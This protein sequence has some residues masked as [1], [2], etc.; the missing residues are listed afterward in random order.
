MVHAHQSLWLIFLLTVTALAGCAENSEVWRTERVLTGIPVHGLH[1]LT[2]GPDGGL[3]VGSVMGQSIIRVD[4]DT[5]TIR[6]VIPAPSGEADDIA[7]GPDGSM[8]W[9][10]LNQGELRVRKPSGEITTV[11]SGL[12]FVNPV[13]FGPD[14]TLYAATLFG[15]DRLWAYDIEV[16]ASRIV[17]ENLG[18][19]NAFEFGDDGALYTPLPQQQSIGKIDVRT[20]AVT[21]VAENVGNVV[22]VKFHPDGFLYGVSWDDGKVVRINTKTGA[23]KI[24]ATVEP[25][26]DNL[27]I[28]KN[29]QVYV[30]RSADNG[31]IV[32]NP[33][34][35]SSTIFIRSDFAAPGGMAWA[36]RNGK[37]QLLITDIFGYRFFDPETDETEML[38]FDL[39]GG[40]SADADS[41]DD[42][43]ALSYVRRDRVLLKESQNNAILQTWNNISTP[44]GVLIEPS[45]TVLVASHN[46]GT[47]IRLDADNPDQRQIILDQLA[48]PVG[49]TW[50]EDGVAVYIVESRLG[51]ITKAAL[52][53]GSRETVAIGLDS[54]ETIALLP[55]GHLVVT[56]TGARRVL[57]IDPNNGSKTIL[58]SDLALGGLISRTPENVG[59][60]TGLAVNTNGDVY[61]ITDAE[62][63]LL[64]LTQTR[65]ER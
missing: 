44:Y 42:R 39:E 38:P 43:I 54:P 19:L 9:T 56:E 32:V 62:N 51:K 16:G 4:P 23:T 17:A 30:T 29:G 18:G 57:A 45:G 6:E 15:P 14:G 10:A 12:P 1:G 46:D 21:I 13:A 24:I 65:R 53:D 3:Y 48:G 35:G 41:R 33:K 50:A 36:N 37:R 60:P 26:L 47:L 34:D 58:A 25:P 11:A 63:G 59:M 31:L 61:V 20:G 49:L 8:A 28:A 5:R 40:A 27:A 7:F 55:D 22:A 52:K 2:F 64:K